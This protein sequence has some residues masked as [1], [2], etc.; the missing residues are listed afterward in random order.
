MP[1]LVSPL[2][3]EFVEWPELGS[4]MSWEQLPRL[5]QGETNCERK[6]YFIW[7]SSNAFVPVV[8]GH[9]S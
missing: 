9:V 5:I 8:F 3:H 6:G 4:F 2:P 7:H 1:N